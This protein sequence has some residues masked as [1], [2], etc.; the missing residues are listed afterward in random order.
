MQFKILSVISPQIC[1]SSADKTFILYTIMLSPKIKLLGT[2]EV[3]QVS[4][5]QWLDWWKTLRVFPVC[6]VSDIKSYVVK[7]WPWEE[8]DVNAV[9]V[10]DLIDNEYVENLSKKELRR[11]VRR[12][13]DIMSMVVGENYSLNSTLN[14]TESHLR[15][16]ESAIKYKDRVIDIYKIHL[17]KTISLLA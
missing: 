2:W 8:T 6:A 4:S 16:A 7:K 1:I 3:L 15:S 10:W 5:M 11:E 14:Q 9:L 12:L 13:Q 17:D